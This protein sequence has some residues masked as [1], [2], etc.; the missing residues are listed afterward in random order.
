MMMSNIKSIKRKA[1]GLRVLTI[2]LLA[3]TTTLPSI[4]GAAAINGRVGGGTSTAHRHQLLEAHQQNQRRTKSGK[5]SKSS[6]GEGSSS[7]A[8]SSKGESSDNNDS[9]GSGS[10][11]SS[12]S[13]SAKHSGKSSKA[14]SS[15]ALFSK[16]AKHSKSTKNLNP[17][18]QHIEVVV[19]KDDRDNKTAPIAT[20][21]SPT[22][23]PPVVVNFIPAYEEVNHDSKNAA[24]FCYGSDAAMVVG[25]LSYVM[26]EMIHGF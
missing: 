6:K 1:S 8:K 9:S 12:N 11:G 2:M 18:A 22:V 17:T 25:L 5:K 24:T 15:K 13:K 26:L 3:L 16:S 7:S 4:D 19:V 20:T 23:S 21:K 14:K 10:S